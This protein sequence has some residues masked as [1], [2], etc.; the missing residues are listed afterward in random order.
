[1]WTDHI[2]HLTFHGSPK[3]PCTL[4]PLGLFFCLEETFI[5]ETFTD[6]SE[7]I[8]VA[9]ISVI[10]FWMPPGRIRLPPTWGSHGTYK[11]DIFNMALISLQRFSS[12]TC[13]FPPCWQMWSSIIVI[14]NM[15]SLCVWNRRM[16]LIFD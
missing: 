10:S 15:C 11:V 14:I 2:G 12:Y 13:V 16:S 1:M 8:P 5:L 3:K 7:V 6:L 9:I 4:L